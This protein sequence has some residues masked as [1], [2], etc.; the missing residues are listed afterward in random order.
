[1]GFYE[2]GLEATGTALEA[3]VE[4]LAGT[5]ANDSYAFP[6]SGL[7]DELE[8]LVKAGLSPAQALRSATL[9]GA[10]FLERTAD[11]GSIAAGKKAD[12]VLLR[13]NPLADIANTRSIE[14]VVFD[15]RLYTRRDLDELMA[16]VAARVAEMNP[17]IELPGNSL[18][19][20]V[21]VYEADMG[22][23]EVSRADG[24]LYLGFPGRG[25]MRPRALSETEF[26]FLPREVSVIFDL[27][28]EGEVAGMDFEQ[29]GQ[30]ATA[31]KVE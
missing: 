30:V 1:M 11:H 2:K 31:L 25:R 26:V 24:A 7:H 23:A 5:D 13:E 4:I 17:G 9:A 19:R 16:D 8:E 20:Y 15:G 21:G 10:D 27:S 22:R 3:G 29:G 14:S 18:E 6:G 28:D 12:L